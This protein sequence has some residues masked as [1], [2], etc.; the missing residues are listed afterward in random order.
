MEDW[1]NGRLVENQ[2]SIIALIFKLTAAEGLS[3]AVVLFILLYQI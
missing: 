1:K 3:P 2:P